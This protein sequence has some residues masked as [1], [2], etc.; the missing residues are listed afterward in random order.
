MNEASLSP[1]STQHHRNRSLRR[2]A[3]GLV[4]LSFALFIE[5][6]VL[7]L[8]FWLAL[9]GADGVIPEFKVVPLRFLLVA[10]FCYAAFALRPSSKLHEMEFDGT[11]S[12]I[13]IAIVVALHIIVFTLIPLHMQND[14]RF[15]RGTT[16]YEGAVFD[17][18]QQY[19]YLADALIEGHVYLDLHVP[20]YLQDMENPYDAQERFRLAYETGEPS[21]WDY[22]FFNG[23]YYCYFG[24]V[25]ALLLFVPYKVITGHDLM[26]YHAVGF[27]AAILC[28]VIASFLRVLLRR[29]YPRASLGFFLLSFM[30]L[31]MGCGIHIQVFYPLFYSLPPLWSLIFLF[32]GFGAFIAA[33]QKSGQ[34]RRG[35]LVAGSFLLALT[36]GCR[37]QFFLFI[38]L[39]I[40]LYWHEIAKQRLFFSKRGTANTL[41]VFAPC[42]VVGLL[43]M[44]YNHARFGSPFDFGAAYN[45]TGFDMTVKKPFSVRIIAYA[46]LF[47][48]FMPLAVKSGFPYISVFDWQPV[49]VEP[50]HGGF[51]AFSPAALSLLALPFVR[52]DLRRKGL[53]GFCLLGIILS[54][55]LMCLSTQMASISMRYM[56]D[57]CF[58]ILVPALCVWI[59]LF[60]RTRSA[61]TIR[62][63]I[64]VFA[65]SV[66]I[67]EALCFLSLLSPDRYGAL[68]LC[69]P[70]FY[71][72]MEQWFSLP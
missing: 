6:L 61:R 44:A 39:V 71:S 29:Y 38:L 42:I 47:Y 59:V 37:P 27:S 54:I 31:A 15:I 12:R 41:A 18:G 58:G 36:M 48:V 50:F 64:A 62:L 25:P 34:P 5:L 45:L 1:E 65:A 52:S 67:G 10:L 13:A 68:A 16:K 14:T 9:P 24:I 60:E 46:L 2:S 28:V 56:S 69:N 63:L 51:F 66:I 26:T 8:G 7:N 33:K 3:A 11:A 30:F 55:I 20:S 32:S 21:Y 49:P 70:R 23:R 22:A 17:D 4:P 57:F 19:A 43:L 53:W 72:I 35:L 40:P